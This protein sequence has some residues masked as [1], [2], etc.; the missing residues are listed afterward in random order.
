MS[1]TQK[2]TKI[3]K[4]YPKTHLEIIKIITYTAKYY[5]KNFQL[6]YVSSFLSA[7]IPTWFS[8]RLSIEKHVLLQPTV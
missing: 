6:H 1:C 3:L 4:I 8:I 7:M 2:L 5:C